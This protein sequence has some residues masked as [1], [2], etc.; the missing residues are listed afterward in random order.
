VEKENN[1]EDKFYDFVFVVKK[2]TK[3][4]RK[5]KPTI[6]SFENDLNFL[7]KKVK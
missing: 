7:I 5:D 4:D 6:K 3:L 1:I 2:Q